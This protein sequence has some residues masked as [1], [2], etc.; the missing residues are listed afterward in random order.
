MMTAR[1]Q[2]LIPSGNSLK[3]FHG[4]A[5]GGGHLGVNRTAKR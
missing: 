2:L 4:S 1:A 3:A 5:H